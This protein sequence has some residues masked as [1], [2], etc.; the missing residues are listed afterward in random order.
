[1]SSRSCFKACD[2]AGCFL[3][4]RETSLECMRLEEEE[5]K[6]EEEEED[7]TLLMLMRELPV[8]VINI[9]ALAAKSRSYLSLFTTL[10]FRREFRRG[11]RTQ[12]RV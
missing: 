9:G 10:R 3:R 12:M 7:G 4:L 8:S 6:E 11:T 2:T 1:M 5:V